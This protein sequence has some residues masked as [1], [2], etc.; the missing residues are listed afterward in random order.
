MSQ[1]HSNY[2]GFVKTGVRHKCRNLM[3]CC[4]VGT[5]WSVLGAIWP[6]LD[7]KGGSKIEVVGIILKND[8]DKRVPNSRDPQNINFVLKNGPRWEG[9]KSKSVRVAE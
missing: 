1:R 2:Y 6:E 3:F 9:L 7:P 5:T 4:P 8:D